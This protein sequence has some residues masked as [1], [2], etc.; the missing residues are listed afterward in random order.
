MSD[1]SDCEEK[2]SN[3]KCDKCHSHPKKAVS[4]HC[5]CKDGHQGPP[6]PAG[7]SAVG[8]NPFW[9]QSDWYVNPVTGSNISNGLT[10]L[11]AVRT[12][13]GGIVPRWGTSS[14]IL[15]STVTIHLLASETFQQEEVVVSPI[16][17]E[18]ANFVI[19]G[20]GNPSIKTDTISSIISVL[21]P[22]VGT[23]LVLTL[24]GGSAGL[25]AG[26]LIRNATTGTCAVIDSIVGPNITVS[27]PLDQAGLTTVSSAP[28]LVQNSAWAVGD[29]LVFY[30]G[31]LLNLKVAN[32]QGGDATGT[33]G[34]SP[35]FWLE[36]IFVPS[37]GGVGNST[38]TPFPMGCSFVASNCQFDVFVTLQAELVYYVGQFQNCWLNGGF[39]LGPFAYIMG[40]SGNAANIN[41]CG[42]FGG[43][44]DFNAI[45]HNFTFMISPGARWGQVQAVGGDIFVNKG[46]VLEIFRSIT[47]DPILWGTSNLRVAQTNASVANATLGGGRPWVTCLRLTG[48][49]AMNGAIT[50]FAFDAGSGAYT[51]SGV[52]I[53]SANLD[54]YGGLHNPATNNSY[55]G[56]WFE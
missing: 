53:T 6:G 49:L 40:G 4:A 45:L 24:T 16:L 25:S 14:P 43:N 29:S 48:T 23:N 2:F 12:I 51:P 46:A 54:T 18:G 21:D 30:N 50:G 39:N 28:A 32:P 42:F 8:P 5:D 7:L 10:P 1:S 47:A 33:F 27:Q 20:E 44:A 38:F 55:S 41:Y 26:N 52:A 13:M 17:T 56:P 19:R 9:N 22:T 35:V 37:L 36:N 15:T 34:D 31:F 11:T 3:D